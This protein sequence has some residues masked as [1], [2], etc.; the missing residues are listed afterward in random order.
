MKE[1]LRDIE[2]ELNRNNSIVS[3][4]SDI[5]NNFVEDIKSD[6]ICSQ[7]ELIDI[8]E[9]GEK[10]YKYNISPGFTDKDK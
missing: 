5:I 8:Y 10:R 2:N 6:I 1:N 7:L 3:R 9:E 4:D